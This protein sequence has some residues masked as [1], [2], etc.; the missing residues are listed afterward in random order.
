MDPKNNPNFSV[1][2]LDGGGIRGI[3]AATVLAKLEADLG[4]P[5][6][7]MFDLMVGT[8]TGGIIALGLSNGMTA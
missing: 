6:Y 1:L 7:E 4:V 3:V 2:S 5:A 8:S